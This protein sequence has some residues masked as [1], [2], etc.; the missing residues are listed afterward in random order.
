[1]ETGDSVLLIDK[2]AAHE[3]ILFDR[4]RANPRFEGGQILLTPEIVEVGA[5]DAALV[6]AQGALLAEYGFDVAPFGETSVAVREIPSYL[7]GSDVRDVVYDL[8]TVLRK[9]GSPA[10]MREDLLHTMACKAAVKA[11]SSSQPEQLAELAAR[12]VSGEVKYCP[13]GRPV[14]MELT[15]AALDKGFRRT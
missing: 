11:G 3:R 6:E 12:V 9:G 4:L 2:H 14:A 7:D 15:R 8:C 13:H 1:M 10:A 5:E